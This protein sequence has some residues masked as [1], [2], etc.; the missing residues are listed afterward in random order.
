MA[1]W[2]SPCKLPV[3]FQEATTLYGEII[4]PIYKIGEDGVLRPYGKYS[5]C[6]FWR[7]LFDCGCKLCDTEDGYMLYFDRCDCN[8]VTFCRSAEI[9]GVH[10]YPRFSQQYAPKTPPLPSK[11]KVEFLNVSSTSSPSSTTT[12]STSSWDSSAASEKK[13]R[14]SSPA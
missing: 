7:K 12:T 3:I 9:D 14:V 6:F 4:Q 5:T 8:R 2:W 13:S 1:L 10:Y 11:R